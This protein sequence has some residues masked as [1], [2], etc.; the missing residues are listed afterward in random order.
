MV[1]LRVFGLICDAAGAMQRLYRYLRKKKQIPEGA[2]L[3]I[4][5]VKNKEANKCS[6]STEALVPLPTFVVIL[7]G[8]NGAIEEKIFSRKSF[9]ISGLFEEVSSHANTALDKIREMIASFG[10]KVN[11]R[12]SKNTSEYRFRVMIYWHINEL[13]FNLNCNW[14]IILFYSISISRKRCRCG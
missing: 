12:F 2:W 10:G 4:K 3:P 5:L 8:G 11:Q 13:W 1:G 9:I 7:L 6:D 14:I